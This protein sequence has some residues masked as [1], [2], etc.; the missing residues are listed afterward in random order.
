MRLPKNAHIWLPGLMQSQLQR[1]FLSPPKRAWLTIADHYEPLWNRVDEQTGAERVKVWRDRWPEIAARFHDSAGR[2]PKY[3]FFFPQEE[4]R[5][6]FLDPLAE[7]TEQGIGDVE[8]HIHHDGEGEQNFIDRMSG[9][10]EVLRKRH[11]LL[12]TIDGK[13]VFGFIHGNWALDNSRPDGRW[14]GLNNELDLLLEL[15]CYADFT[16]PSAPNGT[17]VHMVNTIYWAK[18]DPCCPKSHDYGI[19]VQAGSPDMPGH[20]LMITGPLGLR[21]RSWNAARW[22]PRLDCGEIASYDMPTRAR[23][24]LWLDVG[25]RIGD[26]VFIK[27]YTHGTQERHSAALLNGGLQ[28]LFQSAIEETRQRGMQLY[29]AS[30]WEMRQAVEALRHRQD[31]VCFE[32][33]ETVSEGAH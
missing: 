3:S 17:Q 6:Q 8:I 14:C 23:V 27:L 30:A 15:G 16:E 11:G 13:P 18:D 31:P 26:D 21:G 4:Y 12:H 5:P 2:K 19:P 32:A 28:T 20:L 33:R 22:V 1:K 24:G 25:P 10:V 7:M 9:F 29:F